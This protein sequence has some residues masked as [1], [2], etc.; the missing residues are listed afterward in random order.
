MKREKETTIGFRKSLLVTGILASLGIFSPMGAQA[1]IIP[2]EGIV[3]DTELTS[4]NLSGP[5]V[6]IPL[7]SDPTNSLGDSIEGYGFVNSSINLTLSSQRAVA[8][9][10]ASTGT[11]YI[12]PS[13]GEFATEAAIGYGGDYDVQQ[14]DLLFVDSF[15]DVFFDI[16]VTDVDT[17]AGRDFAG[18]ADGASLPI[19]DNGPASMSLF[20][21]C[22]ADLAQVNFGCLPPVGDAYIGHFDI[23]IPLRGDINGNGELDV[24]K[25]TLGTHNVGSVTDFFIDGDNAFDTFNTT[26]VLDG[27]IQDAI[28]DPPFTI[29]LSGPTTARQQIVVPAQVPEPGSLALFGAGLALVGLRK[30][31][32]NRKKSD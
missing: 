22:Q 2:A 12:Y 10:S 9:G 31:K 29:S 11:A 13:F 1:V 18:Q 16:T 28:T 20:T 17:R 30:I 26:L 25:F 15:F 24:M 23:V 8:P 27:L 19:L 3:V 6:A 32:N 4:F 5:D 21:T 14:D 7:A